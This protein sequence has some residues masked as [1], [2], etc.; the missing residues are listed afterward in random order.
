MYRIAGKDLL[1]FPV[2][3]GRCVNADVLGN[4]RLEEAKVQTTAADAVA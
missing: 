1:P 2:V 4:P 3:N